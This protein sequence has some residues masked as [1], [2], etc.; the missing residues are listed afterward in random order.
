MH[1]EEL[2]YRREINP[3]W[4]EDVSVVIEGCPC[5]VSL[6][7]NLVREKVRM[8]NVEEKFKWVAV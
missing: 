4:V 6:V 5:M 1:R 8:L 2:F 7:G 3:D